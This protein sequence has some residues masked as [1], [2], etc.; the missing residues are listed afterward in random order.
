MHYTWAVTENTEKSNLFSSDKYENFL[1][2]GIYR[3]KCFPYLFESVSFKNFSSPSEYRPHTCTVYF[4]VSII[5]ARSSIIWKIMEQ[6][7]HL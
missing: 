2:W 6:I 5:I 4:K 1:Q 7:I 3:D